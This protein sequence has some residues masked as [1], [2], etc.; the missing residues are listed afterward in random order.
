MRVAIIGSRNFNDYN[1]L[2]E[3]L[4]SLNLKIDLIISGGAKGADTLGEK[5]AHENN[6]PIKIFYPNWD[7]YGKKA[8][9]IRNELIVKNSDIIIAFWDG[10]SKG[11][12]HSINLAKKYN[13]SLIIYNFIENKLY[14]F[15]KLF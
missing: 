4:N 12:N 2:K 8:G 5:Y 9:F 14:K 11:T 10:K 3:I 1:K 15:I 6:I 13:K 7:L